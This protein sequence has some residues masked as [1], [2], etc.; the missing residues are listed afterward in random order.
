GLGRAVV[1]SLSGA[2]AA[3]L[4]PKGGVGSALGALRFWKPIGIVLMTLAGS[5][6]AERYGVGS[7]LGPL[8]VIQGLAVVLALLI[9]E[10]GRRTKADESWETDGLAAETLPTKRSNRD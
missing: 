8:A 10:S 7:I 3:A 2:E 4:A 1:E 5:W 9:H 6:M